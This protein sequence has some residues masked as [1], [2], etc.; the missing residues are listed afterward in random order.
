[1]LDGLPD[2]AINIAHEAVDRHVA[3]GFGSVTALRW[4]GKS[5]E[6]LELSYADL[7]AASARFASIFGGPRPLG[8]GARGCSRCSAVSLRFFYAALGTLKAGMTFTPLFSAFRS[9]SAI[10][11]PDGNR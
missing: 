2:G 1:M 6:R 3:N 5:G 4:L 9:S 11:N 10:P 7:S 8:R